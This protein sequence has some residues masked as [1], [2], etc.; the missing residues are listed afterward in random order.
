MHWAIYAVLSAIFASLV[1]IFAKIGIRGIDSNLVVALRT[2]IILVFAWSIIF[3]Q[4]NFGDLFRI[5]RHSYFFIFLSAIATGFSWL[6]YYRALQLGDISRIEPIDKLSVSLAVI[7][8]FTLLG[9]KMTVGNMIGAIL[10]TLG[11]M[12]SI[13]I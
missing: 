12:S 6:F 3:L 5:S 13:F 4:G 11:V 2:L 10:V 8:A 7:F 9:E 1:P